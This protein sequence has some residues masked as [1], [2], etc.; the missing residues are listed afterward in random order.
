MSK[1]YLEHQR[2]ANADAVWSSYAFP[3]GMEPEA[4]DGWERSA[5]SDKWSRTVYFPADGA[6]APTRKGDFTLHFEMD[7]SEIIKAHA[8][9]DGEDIGVFSPTRVFLIDADAPTLEADY[10]LLALQDVL[11]ILPGHQ[12]F[13][14]IATDNDAERWSLTAAGQFLRQ[15]GTDLDRYYVVPADEAFY[16]LEG[17][18]PDETIIALRNA[19]AF[20]DITAAPTA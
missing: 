20:N 5:G 15:T 11:E 19:G 10:Q 13:M 7:T 18:L 8:R 12:E 9:L 14:L 3:Q 2:Q 17:T 6:D 1:N 16:M 4:C